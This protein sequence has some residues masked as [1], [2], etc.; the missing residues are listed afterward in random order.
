MSSPST[1]RDQRR[2]ARRQQ[3]L[4]QQTERRRVRQRAIRQ[5]RLWRIGLSVAA[6]LVLGLLI[7]GAVAWYTAANAPV[8]P[9][10]PATG[11]TV[12]GIECVSSEGQVAHYHADV[13]LFVN[14]QAQSLPAGIG[15]VE[16]AGSPGPALGVGSPACLYALHTHD[17]TG[18]VHIESP[19]ANH[20][21]RLG[22][23]F[24]LWGKALS[25][26]SFMGLRVTSAQRLQVVVYDEHGT[27]SVYT[28]NP[29]NIPLASHQTIFLLYN[30]P[31]VATAPYT[32]WNGL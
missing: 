31:N 11:Q 7:W 32:N 8:H 3:F 17:A 9:T 18:I 19:V 1:K 6:V 14:G 15:I 21:Y 26:S 4:Q 20:V 10:Q 29:Y 25:P 30:S 5:Q 23:V 16:P 22:N 13:Q 28:A 2:D 12:D 27:K 24:D